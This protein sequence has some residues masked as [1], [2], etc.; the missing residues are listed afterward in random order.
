[1]IHKLIHNRPQRKPAS[2]V[3]IETNP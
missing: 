3:P 2:A 1:M